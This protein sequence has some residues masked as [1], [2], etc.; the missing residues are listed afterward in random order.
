MKKINIKTPPSV[1]IEIGLWN[2]LTYDSGVSVSQVANHNVHGTKN[3]PARDFFSY[4]IDKIREEGKKRDVEIVRKFNR[5]Q[6]INTDINIIGIQV[7]NILREAIT[8]LRDPPNAPSTILT[9]KSSNPLI[10][11]GKMRQAVTWK[12]KNIG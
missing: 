12:I 7:A 4:Y 9:K 11:T 10:D 1:G 5:G 8:D 2:N 3:I 6:D